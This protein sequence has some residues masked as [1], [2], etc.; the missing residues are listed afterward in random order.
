M[1]YRINRRKVRE[2]VINIWTEINQEEIIIGGAGNS[3]Y[4]C[5]GEFYFPQAFYTFLK[6]VI[7]SN[8]KK[9]GMNASD[10]E[11]SYSAAKDKKLNLSCHGDNKNGE[12]GR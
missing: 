12:F 4:I 10:N 6:T 9:H 2:E 11:A 8:Y 3:D 7:Q 5:K 1:S